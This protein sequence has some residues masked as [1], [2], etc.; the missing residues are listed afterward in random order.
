MNVREVRRLAKKYAADL[1][2]GQDT[3]EWAIDNDIPTEM[4]KVFLLELERIAERISPE[5]KR[6]DSGKATK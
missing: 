4:H 6:I 1:L 3:P 5:N 2:R